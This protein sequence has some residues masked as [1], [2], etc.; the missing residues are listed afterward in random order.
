M[1]RNKVL[2]ILLLLQLGLVFLIHRREVVGDQPRPLLLK[3]GIM[4]QA[5]SVLFEWPDG[6]RLNFAKKDDQWVLTDYMDYP[7]NDSIE[8]WLKAISKA[9]IDRVLTSD[10]KRRKQLRTAKEDFE[11]RI[12]WSDG[13]DSDTLL[14]GKIV[15]GRLR[16]GRLK[17]QE[18]VYALAGVR[19]APKKELSSWADPN[20]LSFDKA[21]VSHVKITRGEDAM[22]LTKNEGSFSFSDGKNYPEADALLNQLTLIRS[23]RPAA[24]ISQTV[25][26]ITLE[27]SSASE[28]ISLHIFKLNSESVLV[29]R[30]NLTYAAE[31]KTQDLSQLFTVMKNL[32]N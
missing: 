22:T 3:Q 27:L 10:A 14:L 13:A 8:D 11:N 19:T 7:A 12:T 21:L 1:T 30:T 6:T 29:W 25:P 20:Y 26:D 2:L 23:V 9:K 16:S 15:S 18:K 28:T 24:S 32:K 17:D 4:K 31:V 5:S